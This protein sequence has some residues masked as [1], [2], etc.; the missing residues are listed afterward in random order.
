MFQRVMKTTQGGQ[1]CGSAQEMK[2]VQR[3][4]VAEPRVLQAI[5]PTSSSAEARLASAFLC[6]VLSGLSSMVTASR[7]GCH[8]ATSRVQSFRWFSRL[9]YD[10][11]YKITLGHLFST[12]SLALTRRRVQ[13]I[14]GDITCLCTS[15]S[16]LLAMRLHAW[17]GCHRRV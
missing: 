9:K 5:W 1:V 2:V 8:D 13:C 17:F 12:N 10:P 6:P 14:G 7:R 16:F 4:N 11:Y 15:N 3:H